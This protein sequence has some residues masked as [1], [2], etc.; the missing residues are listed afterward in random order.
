MPR[1]VQR[2]CSP[3]ATP[4]HTHTHVQE[5]AACNLQLRVVIN[6]AVAAWLLS[7]LALLS[8]RRLWGAELALGGLAGEL[9]SRAGLGQAKGG[10][11]G[12]CGRA[13]GWGLRGGLR[14]WL[15]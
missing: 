10:G 4:T 2:L 9:S 13:G 7:L 3:H 6:V 1:A 11:G 5:K 14:P 12:D 8:W 15:P